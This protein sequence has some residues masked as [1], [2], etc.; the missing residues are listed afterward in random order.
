MDTAICRICGRE[1]TN[2]ISVERGIGPVCRA[3]LL[4]ENEG[5]MSEEIKRWDRK[6]NG[7]IAD[8]KKIEQK[9]AV[10]IPVKISIKLEE[11]EDSG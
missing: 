11:A 10:E 7:F 3:R 8:I 1:L 2:P 4:K 6:T 9:Y 5:E